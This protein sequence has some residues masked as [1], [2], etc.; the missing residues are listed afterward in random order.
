MQLLTDAHNYEKWGNMPLERERFYRALAARNGGGMVVLSGDRHSG[1][2]YQA[3]PEAL[4]E[5]LWELTASSLNFSFG[6]GDTGDREPDPT[7]RSG[8]YSGREFRH[9]RD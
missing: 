9:A 6:E 8:F 3:A 2:F 1:A 4:G 5:E 7:R